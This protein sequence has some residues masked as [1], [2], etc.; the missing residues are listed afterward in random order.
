MR[1]KILIVDDSKTIRQQVNF[2]LSQAGYEIIEACDGV[3]AIETLKSTSGIAAIV[4]DVD[5]P[6]MNGIDMIAHINSNPK[7]PHPPI[8]VLTTEEQE[9]IAHKAKQAGAKGW[10]V[11]PFQPEMLVEAI[12]KLLG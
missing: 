8:L 4:T 5:M 7:I 3:E 2:T 6:H 10:I 12:K 9:K 1:Q 11:K